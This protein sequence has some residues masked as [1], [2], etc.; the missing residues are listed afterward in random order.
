MEPWW[1]SRTWCYCMQGW[2]WEKGMSIYW[3]RVE[4][5]IWFCFTGQVVGNNLA[6]GPNRSFPSQKLLFQKLFCG[7]GG[8]NR[9]RG[10]FGAGSFSFILFPCLCNCVAIP[11]L[12]AEV[13]WGRGEELLL[14]LERIHHGCLSSLWL[15]HRGGGERSLGLIHSWPWLFLAVECSYHDPPGLFFFSWQMVLCERLSRGIGGP[16]K[17]QRA[18]NPNT[19]EREHLEG[20]DTHTRAG[21]LQMTAF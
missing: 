4:F 5:P 13:P 1:K 9:Q 11:A 10:Y 14:E 18:V 12:A 15:P 19:A 3:V 21:A 7:W 16:G 20:L 8:D 17:S 6:L 2:C